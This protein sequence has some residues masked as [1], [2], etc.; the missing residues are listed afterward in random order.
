MDVEDEAFAENGE[1]RFEVVEAEG[2]VEVEQ[3]ADLAGIASPGVRASAAC[4]SGDQPRLGQWSPRTWSR[5]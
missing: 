5:L 3:A 4:E 2:V 1:G